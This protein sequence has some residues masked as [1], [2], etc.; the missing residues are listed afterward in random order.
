MVGIFLRLV[1]I[2]I[3]TFVFMY[4]AKYMMRK[5]FNISQVSDD[6][7]S[8]NYVEQRHREVDKPFKDYSFVILFVVLVINLV[9]FPESNRL[10]VIAVL[11]F[12]F[13]RMMIKAFFEWKY[14]EYPKQFI[15]T[16]TEAI[17]LIVVVVIV[18][19][20]DLLY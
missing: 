1:L 17:I 3:I 7:P 4:I 10:L 19:K 6:D 20:F 8:R 2:F 12:I 15:L 11:L 18:V 9:Y 16:L 5:M 13:L 14:F